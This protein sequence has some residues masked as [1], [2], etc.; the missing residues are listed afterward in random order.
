MP[1][2][3]PVIKTVFSAICIMFSFQEVGVIELQRSEFSGDRL[4]GFLD[5]NVLKCLHRPLLVR[6]LDTYLEPQCSPGKGMAEA[7]T[8]SGSKRRFNAVSWAPLSP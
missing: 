3:A 2:L 6:H 7:N 1:R 4:Q 8:P 5:G